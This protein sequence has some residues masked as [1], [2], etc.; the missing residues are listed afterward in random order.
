MIVIP[1]HIEALI[2]DLD[3]TLADTM[4]LHLASWVETGKALNADI[5]EALI[6]QHAGMPTIQLVEKF[7]QE[8]QWNLNPQEVRKTKQHFYDRLKKEQGKIQPVERIFSI[9]KDMRGQLPM[10]IGTGSSRHNALK[11][12]EDLGASD[13]WVTIVTGSD[14]TKGKPSP[15]IF[16]QCASAMQVAPEKCLVFEDGKAGIEAAKA[17]NMPYI[18]INHS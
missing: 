2:F 8:F 13:W 16:L 7:N 4:P 5:T 17:A 6:T 3:G 1:D 18:Y 10:S 11:S 12:L 9:A 14:A 15:E